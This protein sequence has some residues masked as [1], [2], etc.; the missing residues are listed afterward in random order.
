MIA[1]FALGGIEPSLDTGSGGEFRVFSDYESFASANLNPDC[2]IVESN[3][4][5]QGTAILRSLRSNP[6]TSVIPVFLGRS[7]DQYVDAMSD[8]VVSSMN[9]ASQ[10]G[11]AINRLAMELEAQA[12]QNADY[13]LLGYLYSR[14]GTI[15]TP[16]KKWSDPRVYVFPLAESIA[17][18]G[19]NI[20]AWLQGLQ[21]RGFIEPSSLIDRLRHC[22][23]CSSA[24][25]AFVDNCPECNSVDIAQKPVLSCFN[26]GHSAPSEEFR[27]TGEL[28][29][30]KCNSKLRQ[31]GKDYDRTI[32]NFACNRCDSVF[33]EPHVVANCM[34]CEKKIE[35]DNLLIWP[36]Y[37]FRITDRGYMA[38][39]TGT[40]QDIFTILDS[41]NYVKPDQFMF[42]LDW[43]LA[44]QRRYPSD[45]F[46][47]IGVRAR[48]TAQLAQTVGLHK[49]G[50]MIDE[51]AA[52]QCKSIRV[53]DLT[54]RTGRHTIWMIL[55][56]TDKRGCKIL[57]ERLISFNANGQGSGFELEFD[58]VSLCVNDET[59]SGE[60]AEKLL[61]RMM[62]MFG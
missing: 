34:S 43:L 46:G 40:T 4:S 17:D 25:L 39:K 44:L 50:A 52:T 1:Y 47:V 30:P 60:T 27:M 24:H 51:F 36:I 28:T 35:P 53:T 22:P 57:E 48:N 42:L 13:R 41:I 54:T 19:A 12:F 9:E 58:T 56:K 20:W 31:I 8:G 37:S 14:P 38:A 5:A 3:S 49:V 18:Y 62:K 10:K 15:L 32:G 29:C 11:A 55:P 45:I 26:C 6:S 2:F 61:G 21:E 23:Y 16:V 59:P 33:L 7:L